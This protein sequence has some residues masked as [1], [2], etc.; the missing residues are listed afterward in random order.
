MPSIDLKKVYR[1]HYTAK[2][3]P[4]IVEVP[5]RPFLMIDGSGDPNTS[6]DYREAIEAL[7]PSPTACG[8]RSRLRPAMPTR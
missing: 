5:R 8:P 4:A 2:R 6:V 7:Y 1:D 3:T